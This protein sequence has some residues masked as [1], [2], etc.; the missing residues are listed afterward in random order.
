M[1]RFDNI[2]SRLHA[3]PKPVVVN[4]SFP[5]ERDHGWKFIR[6]GPDDMLYVPV[7]APCNICEPKDPR[8][9]T[10][11]RMH[12]DGRAWR[13]TLREF[14]TPWASIGIR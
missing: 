9:A 1:I 14:A 6:F 12:P 11:M 10:I 4:D 2:E 5:K 8:F 3:P 13:S 7:G